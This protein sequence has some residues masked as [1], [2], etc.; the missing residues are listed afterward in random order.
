MSD[1]N[2]SANGD[3]KSEVGTEAKPHVKVKHLTRAD[4]REFNHRMGLSD[5]YLVIG[6]TIKGGHK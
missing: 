1:I 6:N 3:S 4:T 2:E 5:S